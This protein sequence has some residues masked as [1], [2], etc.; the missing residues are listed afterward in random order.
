[1]QEITGRD[2]KELDPE[3]EQRYESTTRKIIIQLHHAHADTRNIHADTRNIRASYMQ[4]TRSIYA[5][6]RSTRSTRI[7]RIARI[8]HASHASHARITRT[9]RTHYMQSTYTHTNESAICNTTLS[10]TFTTQIYTQQPPPISY[11]N[12][13]QTCH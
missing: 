9:Q 12:I 2:V 5:A 6:T 11:H 4:H 8:A 10:I 3:V 1:M 13:V 7:T